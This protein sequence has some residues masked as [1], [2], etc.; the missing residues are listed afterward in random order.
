MF[1]FNKSLKNIVFIIISL[2]LFFKVYAQPDINQCIKVGVLENKYFNIS[3]LATNDSTPVCFIS[4]NDTSSM[5][6]REAWKSYL[7]KA[8][9]T[10]AY[11]Y[12]DIAGFG[13]NDN[14]ETITSLDGN[15]N[16]SIIFLYCYNNSISK[17]CINNCSLLEEISCFANNLF[18]LDITNCNSLE[19]LD[20][21]GNYFSPCALDSIFHQLPNRIDSFNNGYITIKN[22]T[23][24][25][26]GVPFCR[27]TIATN[28]KWKVQDFNNNDPKDI[29]N[30]VY[31]CPYFTLGIENP[32]IVNIDFNIFPNPA[33]SI[34]NIRSKELLK[35]IEILDITGVKILEAFN[36]NV[37][38]YELSI[39]KLQKG[40]YL[41]KLITNSGVGI[42]KIVKR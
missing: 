23:V 41:M 26:P 19:Y 15:N 11:F 21:E 1:F 40:I 14:F 20:C 5:I 25:N 10:I 17:L 2:L 18:N 24:T 39:N 33:Y 30:T 16:Q 4:G 13:C 28:K 31:H 27:D 29:I 12:G 35:T 3:F 42:K 37:F 9:D 34:I 7:F 38:D 22:D 6:I 32:T 36:L 8:K